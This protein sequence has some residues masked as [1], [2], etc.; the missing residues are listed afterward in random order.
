[1]QMLV[2]Q[3]VMILLIQFPALMASYVEIDNDNGEVK[4]KE[5]ADY[6]NK[7]IYTFDVMATDGELSDT[8]T[9]TVNVTDVNEAPILNGSNTTTIEENSSVDTVIFHAD[10][11]DPDGDDLTYS[12]SGTDASY[13]EIDNDNG[14]VKLKEPADYANKDIYTFD[15]MATDGELSDTQTAMSHVTDVNEAPILNGSNTTTIEENSSVDTVIFHADASDPDGDDLTY[16][17]SGTD[18]ST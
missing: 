10:A 2:I 9:T 17:V 13:V 7:D 1:M 8:Q 12:V 15:V 18:A 16:S 3:M 11:S 14:E 6:E 4:L 5:P